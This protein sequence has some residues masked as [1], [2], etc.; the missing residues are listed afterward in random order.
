MEVEDGLE[1]LQLD[2][3]EHSKDSFKTAGVA[4]WAAHLNNPNF[5]EAIMGIVSQ[6]GDTSGNAQIV[7]A[8]VGMKVGYSRLPPH[9]LQ[10]M[11]KDR[12]WL[13]KLV[14]SL[15]EVMGLN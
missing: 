6:G 2:D 12:A 1:P 15:L 13:N 4:Y 8:I 3:L 10:D 9:L 14:D 7:G 11:G 5:I